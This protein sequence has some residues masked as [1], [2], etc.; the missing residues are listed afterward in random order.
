M[1]ERLQKVLAHAGVASRRAAEELIVQ[2]RVTVNGAR[3]DLGDLADPDADRIEV[4]GR[5]VT[6]LQ[7]RRHEYLLLYK[8]RF[9][10]STASDPEGRK[11]VLDLVRSRGRI[12][13]VGRLDFDSEGLLLLTDD[14]DLTYRLTQARFGV[15]KE[16]HV[17][18]EDFLDDDRIEELRR[19]VMLEDGPAAAER[20]EIL[21]RRRAGTWLRVVLTE[22]RQRQVRRMLQAVGATVVRL[23]RERMGPLVLGDLRPGESRH[24]DAR[25]VW[26]LRRAVG[27]EAAA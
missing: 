14:G 3:A 15:E 11:T 20:V 7:S 2:G 26:S 22:G 16:Y 17:L 25:E 1:R 24:L 18:V 21:D 5:P 27:L 8:P 9:V 4:D 6:P 23:R 19:G 12:Y 10:V 13:P